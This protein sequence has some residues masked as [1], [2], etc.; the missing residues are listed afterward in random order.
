MAQHSARPVPDANLA[1]PATTGKKRTARI[2]LD[3]YK[4]GDDLSRS[5]KRLLLLALLAAVGYIAVGEAARRGPRGGSAGGFG[6]PVAWSATARINHRN[7][8]V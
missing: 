3:Y 2:P 1:A 5:R 7:N 4:R 6:L 8:F